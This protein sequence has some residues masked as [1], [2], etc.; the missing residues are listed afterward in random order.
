MNHEEHEKH[1]KTGLEWARHHSAIT[2]SI[3]VRR[4]V[5]FVFFVVHA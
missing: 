5:L 1:E 4:F 2:V 3:P